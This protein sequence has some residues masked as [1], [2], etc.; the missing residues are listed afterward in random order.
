MNISKKKALYVLEEIYETASHASLTGALGNGDEALVYT[1]NKIRDYAIKN[2]WIEEELVLEISQA[3]MKEN[4]N[5]MDDI[6]TSAK[7]FAALL[8]DEE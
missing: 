2:E 4:E 5:W 7:I 8:R 1:Y 6:G 3:T